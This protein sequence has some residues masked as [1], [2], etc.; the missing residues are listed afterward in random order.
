ML[1]HKNFKK[2][3]AFC[4][5]TSASFAMEC[6]WNPNDHKKGEAVT[7]MRPVLGQSAENT[8]AP[9]PSIIEYFEEYER[10]RVENFC[11][12]YAYTFRQ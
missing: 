5:L 12:G 1:N 2:F 7:G 9:A 4:L 8:V 3:F 6:E 10:M 11:N